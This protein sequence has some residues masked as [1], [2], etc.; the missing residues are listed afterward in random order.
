MTDID[1]LNKV[2]EAAAEKF[3]KGAAKYGTF[4]PATD[5]RDFLSEAEAEIL[6]AIN[7]LAMLLM[8]MEAMKNKKVG[9]EWGENDRAKKEGLAENFLTP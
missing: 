9:R 7:Y 1:Q 8:K 3:L 6:D 2:F 5:T 4:N